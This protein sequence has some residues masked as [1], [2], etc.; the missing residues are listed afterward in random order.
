MEP[1]T[2]QISPL[3]RIVQSGISVSACESR[4][5][6]YRIRRQNLYPAGDH[7]DNPETTSI[8]KPVNSKV[9]G[10][11]GTGTILRMAGINP[12]INIVPNPFNRQ[13]VISVGLDKAS[14][15][16]IEL[17][18]ALGQ[19]VKTLADR[20]MVSGQN[21]FVWSGENDS[22]RKVNG[23]VYFCRIVIGSQQAAVRR[24]LVTD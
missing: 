22:G 15:I 9:S 24:I 16:S 14:E 12:K 21:R 13:T 2:I 6:L 4:P 11:G 17:Y 18:N 23:G 10:T 8:E 19:K 7:S 5:W 1:D 3:D 20:Q